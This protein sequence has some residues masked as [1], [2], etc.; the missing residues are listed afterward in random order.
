MTVCHWHDWIFYSF[1]IV[2]AFYVEKPTDR[3]SKSADRLFVFRTYFTMSLEQLPNFRVSFLLAT[4]VLGLL[5]LLRTS[6]T[7][8]GNEV[9]DETTLQ[10][11]IITQRTATVLLGVILIFLG[12]AFTAL[13][14]NRFVVKRRNE[15][16]IVK[17]APFVFDVW[18]SG[19]VGPSLALFALLSLRLFLGAPVFEGDPPSL[20]FGWKYGVTAEGNED[21]QDDIEK[22]IAF[23]PEFNSYGH[24]V[25]GFLA[26]LFGSSYNLGGPLRNLF[27]Y[28]MTLYPTYNLVKRFLGAGDAFAGSSFSNNGF[29]WA[30]GF[31]LG[32]AVRHA[33]FALKLLVFVPL[34][35]K[36]DVLLDESDTA[37]F[38]E[39]QKESGKGKNGRNTRLPAGG[40]DSQ[41]VSAMTRFVQYLLAFSLTATV[42]AA[43][44][45]FGATWNS[46]L[47]ETT[48]VNAE[49]QDQDVDGFSIKILTVM[50][51]VPAFI[52][53]LVALI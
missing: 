39:Y 7:S 36:G 44:I 32:L 19:V 47:E 37:S 26:S 5:L 18:K 48:C 1:L 8:A 17:K 4:L 38:G 3:S 24:A 11:K 15:T 6:S 23:T 9:D 21:Y 12:L 22:S 2:L 33:F 40:D 53:G 41:N 20:D 25:Q 52:I 29:E 16:S 13:A 31:A 46:C 34:S 45:L 49:S 14:L 35:W 28:L 30:A 50:T 51:V 27:P 43:A 42:F 10:T